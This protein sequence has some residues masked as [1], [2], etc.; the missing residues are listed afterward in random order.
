MCPMR[1]RPRSWGGNVLAH[2]VDDLSA[3]CRAGRGAR[4]VV[5]ERDDGAELAGLEEAGQERGGGGELQRAVPFAEVC[6]D[7]VDQLHVVHVVVGVGLCCCWLAAAAAAEGLQQQL[8]RVC[9]VGRRQL[10]GAQLL[11]DGGCE[12]CLSCEHQVLDLE[13]EGAAV[14]GKLAVDGELVVLAGGAVVAP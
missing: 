9:R 7:A 10:L 12:R 8:D 3:V 2:L 6:V 4:G 5:E 13:L 14:R 11:V 1:P